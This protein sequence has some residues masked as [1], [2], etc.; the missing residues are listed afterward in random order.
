MEKVAVLFPVVPGKDA[1]DVA[2]VFDG[3]A[4]EYAE[5]RRHLGMHVERAYQQD[6]P[7]GTFVVVYVESDRPFLEGLGRIAESDL[8]I[9][10]DF[11]QAVKEVHGVDPAQPPPGEPPEVLADWSDAS[12]TGRRPGFAFCAPVAPGGTERGRAFTKEAY[13]ARVDEFTATRRARGLSHELVCLNHTP[14]GD[15]ICVYYEAEDP[16]AANRGLAESRDPFDVWFKDQLK[17]IFPP[18]IDFDEPVQGITEI[19]DSEQLPVAH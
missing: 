6:T 14:M 10:R 19:F 17:T 5:S 16:D 7:M 11:L 8:G 15:V 3:R 18:E 2:R 1:R 9:D 12:V 13:E 4:E